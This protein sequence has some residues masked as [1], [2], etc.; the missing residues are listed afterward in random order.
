[1]V[2]RMRRGEGKR[3]E[4]L[5]RSV[6]EISLHNFPLHLK[7]KPLETNFNAKFPN[8]GNCLPNLQL[9]SDIHQTFSPHPSL[10]LHTHGKLLLILT[11]LNIKL[12]WLSPS[13]CLNNP[14][15][16]LLVKSGISIPVL[17]SSSSFLLQSFRSCSL[18]LAGLPVL[19]D[20]SISINSSS[21]LV[22]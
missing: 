16:I 15:L 1:M 2:G 10:P 21:C 12:L 22:K 17:Y 6:I 14:T 3:V 18:L 7:I 4:G 20:S 11:I 5:S 8:F 9:F 13:H 19:L